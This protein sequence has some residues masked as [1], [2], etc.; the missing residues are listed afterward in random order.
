MERLRGEEAFKSSALLTEKIKE[1]VSRAE[2]ILKDEDK[3]KQAC[4]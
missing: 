1:D 2:E 3:V 4:V